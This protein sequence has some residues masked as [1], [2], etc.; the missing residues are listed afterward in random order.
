[1]AKYS[2]VKDLEIVKFKEK[3]KYEISLKNSELI[4]NLLT[5]DKSDNTNALLLSNS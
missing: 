4:I 5:L 3:S 1:M 2:S